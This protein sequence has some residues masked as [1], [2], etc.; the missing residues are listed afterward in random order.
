MADDGACVADDDGGNRRSKIVTKFL[1]DT[2]R[3]LQPGRHHAHAVAMLCGCAARVVPDSS[4]GGD[5][6]LVRARVGGAISRVPLTTGS[7]AEFYVQP[8][9][10]CVGDVDLMYFRGA[11][12]AIPDG[13]PPPTELPEEFDGRVEV[14]EIVDAEYPGYVHLVWSYSLTEDGDAGGYSAVRHDRRHYLHHV[15]SEA[16][17]HGPAATLL[18]TEDALS[19]DGVF[20]VRC[21][22]WPPQADNW[23]KRRRNYGWPDSATVDRVVS[24]GCDVV[25]VAHRQCR[26]DEWMSR[27]QWRLSFSRAEIVLLNSWMPVQ[28]IV[29][30]MLR[31]FVKRERLA[32]TTD[33]TGTKIFS[34][35]E[36]KT[37]MLWAC[38]LKPHGWWTDDDNVV[39]ICAELLHIFSSLLRNKICRHY[40]VNSCNLMSSTVQSEMIVSQLISISESWLSTWFVNSYL[41]ECAELCDDRLSRLFD[42]VGTTVKLEN[43]V[44]AVVDWRRNC[45]SI[46]LLSVCNDAEYYVSVN[47]SASPLTVRSAG[48]WISELVKIEPCLRDYF[49]AF[50]F[51]HAATWLAEHSLSDEL[52]DVLAALV[53]QSI[54]KERHRNK[55]SSELSLN[56]AVIL[57]K[58][59][60][61]SSRRTVQQPGR[62][63]FELS[64]AYL[65]RALRCKDS[66]SDSTCCLATVYLAVLYF[67]SRH[68]QT[69]IDH[70]ALVTRSRDHSQCSS[71]VVQGDLLPN[72]DDNIDTVLGLAVFY[73]YVRTTALKQQQRKHVVVF[74]TELFAHYLYVRCLS[75]MTCCRFTETLST[76]QFQ[77]Y[78]AYSLIVDQLFIA[79]VLLLKSA[80]MLSKLEFHYKPP[81][82]QRRNSV[83]ESDTSE[84]LESLQ[85]S[86]LEHLTTFRRLKAQ[87]FA[88]VATVVTTDF[89]ALYAYKRRDYRRCLLLCAQ[90]VHTLA[91]ADVITDVSTCPEFIRLMDDDV[92]S[93]TALTLIV[94]RDCRYSTVT[95]LVSP[96]TLS[97]YLMAQCQLKL[98][99]CVTLLAQ[100]LDYV[101]FVRRKC[102]RNWQ[103]EH[104][105]LKLTKRKVM[106]YLSTIMQR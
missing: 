103:L 14:C 27:Y 45:A 85:Q 13:C 99:H 76:E 7:S 75:V 2:C 40:F 49:T 47:V 73:Q 6:L 20:C 43:A 25:Q 101:E 93:L 92:V 21:L 71:R 60:A 1:F 61:N 23:P 96:L 72:I 48:Y 36:L 102:P 106:I 97:L 32:D 8:M 11:E 50:V 98:R 16:A 54:G 94:D 105:I 10:S 56:Q 82:E 77:R 22:L 53:G 68:Y 100:T 90:N 41:R 87:R 9:L 46:D 52:L 5:D 12:L 42:D 17:A 28:Q 38:E 37:L 83:T 39:K 67:N 18:A 33:D 58:L 88:S 91:Y 3:L 79:D 95:V 24:N 26:Q 80:E 57:M 62:M 19:Y 29:Y 86:A 89:E 30:H 81:T 4:A 74:T 55:L 35:Y 59:G 63:E 70:C 78:T 15:R 104:L 31:F 44:S 84:L 34:N 69:V 51:L 65:Y 64:K 66:D